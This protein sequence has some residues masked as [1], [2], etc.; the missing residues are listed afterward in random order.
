MAWIFSLSVEFGAHEESA[1]AAEAHFARIGSGDA[2]RTARVAPFRDAEGAWWVRV[3]PE[4][5]GQRGAEDE[6]EERRMA[7]A[8]ALLYEA[9]RTFDGYRYALVGVEVDEFRTYAE[10]IAGGGPDAAALTGLVVSD[11]VWDALGRPAAFERFAPGYRW[12]PS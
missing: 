5:V 12:I 4:G 8:A 7:A 1:R 3:E 6:A 2:V 10:L 11:T 9:L